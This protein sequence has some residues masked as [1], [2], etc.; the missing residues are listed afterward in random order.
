MARESVRPH[1]RA[2]LRWTP[3][4]EPKLWARFL[5]H[6]TWLQRDCSSAKPGNSV[7]RH[8]HDEANAC[9][10]GRVS[11][12]PLPLSCWRSTCRRTSRAMHVRIVPRSAACCARRSLD[13]EE[14]EL[15]WRF[16]WS[17]TSEPRALTKFLAC[18]DWSDILVRLCQHL[19]DKR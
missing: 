10:T 14:K 3:A 5:F 2:T 16:R 8:W 17:L 19:H 4:L 11:Q 1:C 12:A 15:I 9:C 7:D 13:A 6:S 18:V